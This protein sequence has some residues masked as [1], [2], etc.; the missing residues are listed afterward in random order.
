MPVLDA[1]LLQV[2]GLVKRFGGFTALD[3]IDLTVRPGEIVGLIGP[4]GSGKTTLINVISG[5][6][7][8]DGGEISLSGRSLLGLAAHRRAAAGVNRTFQVPKPF[9]SLTVWQNLEVAATRGADLHAVLASVE[10]DRQAHRLAADLNSVS[11][12]MLDLARALVTHPRLLLVDELACGLNLAELNRV[13]TRL[14][15][16]A[17][18]GMG[19]VVVEHLMSFIDRITHR[20]VVMNAGREI[21]GGLL[22]DASQDQ[23]VIEVFLGRPEPVR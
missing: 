11:Q 14:I 21:F 3:G 6:L 1:P 15:A 18:G 19:L 5:L 13:A 10:L 8:A 2:R 7:A 12:K 22:R 20:V 23:A 9:P 17:E 16:L 4:N